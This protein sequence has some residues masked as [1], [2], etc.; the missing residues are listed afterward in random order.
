[1]GVAGGGY[2]ANGGAGSPGSGWQWA[3]GGKRR[4]ATEGGR[5]KTGRGAGTAADGGR[6]ISEYMCNI[7]VIGIKSKKNIGLGRRQAFTRRRAKRGQFRRRAFSGV[8]VP[9]LFGG[10]RSAGAYPAAGQRVDYP[11]A[12]VSIPKSRPSMRPSRALI[13]LMS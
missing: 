8:S 13:L 9:R 12:G 10:R 4:K 2:W 1:M 6:K 5:W 11:A 7:C 3:Q